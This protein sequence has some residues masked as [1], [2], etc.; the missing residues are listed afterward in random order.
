[1]R[2]LIASFVLTLLLATLTAGQ[3]RKTF[4]VGSATA[5]RGQKI[6]GTI[7][8]PPGVDAG[9]SIP[10]A[11]IHGAKPGPVLALVAGS[12]GTE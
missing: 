7:E 10:V 9:L 12:H 6:T 2:L 5:P 3:D 4:S 8:V 1:M 11:V